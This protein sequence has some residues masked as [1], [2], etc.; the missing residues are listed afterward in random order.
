MGISGR[1]PSAKRTAGGAV[2]NRG[3][4]DDATLGHDRDTGLPMLLR[5][6]VRLVRQ[7]QPTT[8][9]RVVGR[10]WWRELQ[11]D[12]SGRAAGGHGQLGRRVRVGPQARD[13]AARWAGSTARRRVGAVACPSEYWMRGGAPVCA[14]VVEPPLEQLGVRLPVRSQRRRDVQSVAP[15]GD[16]PIVSKSASWAGVSQ[17]VSASR[18]AGATR[19]GRRRAAAELADHQA[20]PPARLLPTRKS[21]I[22]NPIDADDPAEDRLA[23]R[24]VRAGNPRGASR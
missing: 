23:A 4:S 2:G 21:K 20:T 17:P 15:V 10:A 24:Q 8:R 11:L 22:G 16:G 19:A 14:R 13:L 5:A 18:S 12:E 6:A 9:D 1:R 7:L 3:G